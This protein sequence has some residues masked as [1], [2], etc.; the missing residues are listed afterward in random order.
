MRLLDLI[1]CPLRHLWV[2]DAGQKDYVGRPIHRACS[3]CALAQERGYN[4]YDYGGY[5]GWEK[6]R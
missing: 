4:G 2:Y 1:P 5:G 3:R 6:A